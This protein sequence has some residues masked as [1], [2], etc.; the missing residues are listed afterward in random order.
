MTTADEKR[1][2][3]KFLAAVYSEEVFEGCTVRQE[4]PACCGEIIDLFTDKITFREI[5]VGKKFFHLLEPVCPCCGRRVDAVYH[6]LS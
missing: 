4:R 1:A 3:T 5:T 2:E 6:V